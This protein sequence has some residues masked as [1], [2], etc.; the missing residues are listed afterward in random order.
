MNT[1]TF[2][3]LIRSLNNSFI[4]AWKVAGE[5]VNPK[6]MTISLKDPSGVV[7]TAFH[8][9]SFLILTLLYP[10]LKSIF[11][12]TFLVPMFS[13]TSEINGSG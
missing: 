7:N 12:N 10:Y 6:N 8:L 13:N 2:L 5:F 11:V 9:S 1:A 4:M 3:V